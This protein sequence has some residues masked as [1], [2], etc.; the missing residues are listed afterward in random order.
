MWTSLGAVDYSAET[1]EELVAM[2]G[3]RVFTWN[4]EKAYTRPIKVKM[5]SSSR[6]A[7]GIPIT[8]ND[9]QAV[10]SANP[11]TNWMYNVICDTSNGSSTGGNVDCTILA[12]VTI[13]YYV[14]FF[15]QPLVQQS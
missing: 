2:K 15:N 3:A 1:I 14:E 10:V 4:A 6:R 12:D 11:V 7:T 5:Y 13:D 9:S 8:D